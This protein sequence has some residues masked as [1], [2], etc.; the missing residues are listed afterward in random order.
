MKAPTKRNGS[1]I[2]AIVDRCDKDLSQLGL[3]LAEGRSF[4][5]GASH[6]FAR[7][8]LQLAVG[9]CCK[10]PTLKALCA[11]WHGP[12]LA[13][14]LS[15]RHYFSHRTTAHE[16]IAAPGAFDAEPFALAQFE[17]EMTMNYKTS[18]TTHMDDIE[19][20]TGY[21]TAV[22]MTCPAKASV[23][24]KER[25]VAGQTRLEDPMSDK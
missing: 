8:H 1:T 24:D 3:T 15:S 16:C 13:L 5:K 22:A 19:F 10:K 14:S 2:V 7:S 18:E 23:G 9:A 17:K 25:A 12:H 4:R 11:L 20:A 21:G 6:G